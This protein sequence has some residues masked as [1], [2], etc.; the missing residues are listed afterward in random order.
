MDAAKNSST[1]LASSW[2]P[3]RRSA[4]D[5][6]QFGSS[7][8]QFCQALASG[9]GDFGKVQSRRV[10]ALRPSA[11]TL[12]CLI[13]SWS[14]CAELFV[15]PNLARCDGMH[16]S[17]FHLPERRMQVVHAFQCGLLILNLT[18]EC[19]RLGKRPCDT[20]RGKAYHRRRRART[21][22]DRIGGV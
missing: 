14:V 7:E 8:I 2:A 5:A 6:D 20:R 3:R 18:I 19:L 9:C 11:Q 1:A 12:Y 21:R 22:V 17:A 16:V 10:T 13:P 4:G 15:R